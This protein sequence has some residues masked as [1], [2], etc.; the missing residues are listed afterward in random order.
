MI[1]YRNVS[2]LEFQAPVIRKG[3]AL[4]RSVGCEITDGDMKIT[5][6]SHSY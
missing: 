1:R 6:I 5:F 4:F 2:K 3:Y